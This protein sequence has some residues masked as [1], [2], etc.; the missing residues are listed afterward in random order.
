[1]GPYRRATTRLYPDTIDN[2]LITRRSRR[3]AMNAAEQFSDLLSLLISSQKWTWGAELTPSDLKALAEDPNIRE[4]P[5]S[6]YSQSLPDGRRRRQ[7][8]STNHVS[9]AESVAVLAIGADSPNSVHTRSIPDCL[10]PLPNVRT[11]TWSLAE[12]VSPH[13][14]LANLSSAS[15]NTSVSGPVAPLTL[16]PIVE[17][18]A[19]NLT[20]MSTAADAAAMWNLSS[21]SSDDAVEPHAEGQTTVAD[22][23]RY[24][25]AQAAA[26]WLEESS[27]DE[28]DNKEATHPHSTNANTL[29]ATWAISSDDDLASDGPNSSINAPAMADVSLARPA[30]PGNERLVGVA[31]AAGVWS[32]STDSDEDDIPLLSTY[33]WRTSIPSNS[34]TSPVGAADVAGAWYSSDDDESTN[35]LT[36]PSA[37]QHGSRVE[38]LTSA[39]Q[40]DTGVHSVTPTRITLPRRPFSPSFFDFVDHTWLQVDEDDRDPDSEGQSAV[41]DEDDDML[42]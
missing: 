39:V 20:F 29:A 19:P 4:I 36:A 14:N 38:S 26:L 11:T 17:M 8:C 30:K 15:I 1:M 2:I 24:L 28:S 18:S 10:D 34:F 13:E 7:D 33:S 23:T 31:E 9:S 22:T 12:T 3:M 37:D 42:L 27:D 41:D 16:V 25:A 35:C 40:A 21:V 6:G 32:D 5:H